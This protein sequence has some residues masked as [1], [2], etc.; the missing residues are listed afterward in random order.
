MRLEIEN[1]SG[2]VLVDDI[3]GKILSVQV[4]NAVK[5]K[6]DSRAL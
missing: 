6:F 1:N 2:Y 5:G 3:T 4:D